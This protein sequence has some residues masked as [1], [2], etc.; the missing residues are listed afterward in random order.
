MS[1][2]HIDRPNGRMRVSLTALEI[3]E[4][5]GCARNF[6]SAAHFLGMSQPALS[7]RIRQLEQELGMPL[8]RRGHR[9]VS[10]THE[11]EELL[12]VCSRSLGEIRQ[13]ITRLSRAKDDAKVLIAT[14]F[15]FASFWIMPRLPDFQRSLPQVEI[16]VLATQDAAREAPE[17]VDLAIYLAERREETDQ[18]AILFP[19]E[20]LP[21]CSPDYLARHGPLASTDELLARPLLHLAGP[22]DAPWL[23]WRQWFERIGLTYAPRSTQMTLSNYMLVI[24]AALSGRGICLGWRGLVDEALSEGQLVP[25]LDM[26]IASGR[27]YHIECFKAGAKKLTMK[28]FESIR[29]AAREHA[30]VAFTPRQRILSR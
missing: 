13:A 9:G 30:A 6:T 26:T 14:D 18:R 7:H 15:A 10:L 29:L 21:V 23:T 4:A 3:F 12:S 22:S 24:Q 16:S 28:M 11:G 17:D 25:A 8:F 27:A 1:M 20:A 5:A 2:E 19:E